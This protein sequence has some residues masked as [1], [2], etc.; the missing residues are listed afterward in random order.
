MPE[1]PHAEHG[2]AQDERLP[3][4]QREP[5]VDH[6]DVV[7]GRDQHV[8][9]APRGDVVDPRRRRSTGDVGHD[10]QLVGVQ[11][12]DEREHDRILGEDRTVV[13]EGDDRCGAA[14]LDQPPVVVEH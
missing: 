8:G 2:A 4:P 10:E 11:P 5:A 12:T 6:G 7:V 14:E 13:T 3:R 9:I 1:D